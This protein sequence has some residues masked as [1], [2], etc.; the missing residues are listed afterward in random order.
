MQR[1]KAREP[2]SGEFRPNL[3]LLEVPGY[4]TRPV[5]AQAGRFVEPHSLSRAEDVLGLAGRPRLNDA[6]PEP[7]D[8]YRVEPGATTLPG[9]WKTA[10]C[11]K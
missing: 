1:P 5:S 6:I 11:R 10:A 4:G 2:K 8:R 3:D 9:R 7:G